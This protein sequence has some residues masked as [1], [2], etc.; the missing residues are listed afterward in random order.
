MLFNSLEFVAF[1][2]LVAGGYALCPVTWRRGF[3][4]VASYLF[5]CTWSL[6]FAG[7]LLGVSALAF[8]LAR[9]IAAATG[10]TERRRYLAVGV[11]LL[12]SPLVVFKYA[13]GAIAAV[14]A[15]V[16]RPQWSSAVSLKFIGAVGIS[17]Y[18]LKLVSYLIDVYWGR[19]EPCH[20]FSALATYAAFFPQILSGPIQRAGGLL[21][22]LE[23]GLS[24]NPEMLA[25]GLRLLLFGFF[26]KLVVADRLG[27]VVDQV[28]AHPQEFSAKAL[29]LCSYMFA[30]QLYADFSG[31]TDIA[32]GTA[33]LFGIRS[34][35]NFDAP[36][37]AQTIQDFWRRW[38]MTLTGWLSDYLFTPLR[39]GLREYGQIGLVL[40]IVI[41]MVAVGVWHGATWTFVVFGLIHAGYMTVSSLT[42]RPRKRWWS[43]RPGWRRVHAVVGPAITF[44]LVVASF[45]VF[46]ASTV[47]DAWFF[48]R[49]T[50]D[51]FVSA[52][53]GHGWH[54]GGP[55][56]LRHLNWSPGDAVVV[57]AALGIMEMIHLLQRRQH[58][59]V[60][61]AAVPGWIRWAGYLTVAFSILIWGE[62]G[63][64]QFIYVKF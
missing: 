41:N 40:S 14:A 49:T 18:T 20:E 60:V 6:P 35:R 53:G 13:D 10:D 51:A 4:L 26:K 39:M 7:L 34:P 9:R 33:R 1:L 45:V 30:V 46:R 31:L 27:V 52:I 24:G 63:T 22:Q 64:H 11:V 2:T 16:G 57:L 44:N 37:Y 21:G 50:A 38:H 19:V 62:S 23:E 55:V 54:G 8:G 36:F 59:G 48:A 15:A 56:G 29:V 58:L 25:S 17:Y 32:I 43:Q 3:L 28:F 42:M 47:A 12:L 5:Y 61:V